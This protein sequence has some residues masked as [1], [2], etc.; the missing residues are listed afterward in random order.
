M[1]RPGRPASMRDITSL[2]SMWIVTGGVDS[3]RPHLT[4]NMCRMIRTAMDPLCSARRDVRRSGVPATYPCPRSQCF[5]REGRSMY[6]CV[7]VES[8]TDPSLPAV[9]VPLRMSCTMDLPSS[10]GKLTWPR[11][12]MYEGG[13]EVSCVFSFVEDLG[14]RIG[15]YECGIEGRIGGAY[16]DEAEHQVGTGPRLHGA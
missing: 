11:V 14:G 8:F 3:S 2:L 7:E 13:I 5:F 4:V 1:L 16:V 9:S 10:R 6:P 12:A 15:R